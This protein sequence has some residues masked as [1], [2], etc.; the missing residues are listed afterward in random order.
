MF[1]LG[2]VFRDTMLSRMLVAA[3]QCEKCPNTETRIYLRELP[4]YARSLV[5]GAVM[6]KSALKLSNTL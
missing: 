4:G 6:T 1:S 3:G 2:C 5:V